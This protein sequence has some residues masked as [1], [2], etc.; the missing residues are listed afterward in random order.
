[1]NKV[2]AF[3]FSDCIYDS[4]AE[5]VSLHKTEPGARKAMNT[6]VKNKRKH[7]IAIAKEFGLSV[8]CDPLDMCYYDVIEMVVVND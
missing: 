5:T 6:Y 1:M 2:Y 3:V 7:D 8:D 4:A